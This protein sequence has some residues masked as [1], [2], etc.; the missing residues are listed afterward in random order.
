MKE[1]ESVNIVFITLFNYLSFNYQHCHL[2]NITLHLI[3]TIC[4]LDQGLKSTRVGV[5]EDNR[6]S[7]FQQCQSFNVLETFRTIVVVDKFD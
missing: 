6:E 4:S 7:V 2:I 1:R 5:S 3:S